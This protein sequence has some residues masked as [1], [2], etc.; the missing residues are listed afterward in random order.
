VKDEGYQYLLGRDDIE[1]L[2]DFLKTKTVS[3]RTAAE[4]IIHYAMNDS[5]PSW[6][7]DISDK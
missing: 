3:S 6:I 4:F 7:D 5:P 2:L 1:R